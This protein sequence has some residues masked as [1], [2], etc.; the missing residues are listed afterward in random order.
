ML[1]TKSLIRKKKI[2][3]IQ[4]DKEFED[5]NIDEN[6]KII[7]NIED[8]NNIAPEVI[9]PSIFVLP[10]KQ[11]SEKYVENDEIFRNDNIFK[12]DNIIR[13]GRIG[14]IFDAELKKEDAKQDVIYDEI[15]NIYII[16]DY[17]NQKK[18]LK[19]EDILNYIFNHKDNELIK[20]YI[21]TINYNM[22]NK[23]F[24]FNLIVS[25]FTE[26]IEI[27]IKL[28]NFINDYINNNDINENIDK[29]IIF[30][31]QVIIFLFK[32]ILQV[33]KYDKLKLAKYSSY[34]S[35]KYSTMVLKKISNIEY[36]NLIIKNNLQS[37]FEIKNNLLTKLNEISSLQN[38]N[39]ERH[40]S[41]NKNITT[42]PSLILN[43]SAKYKLSSEDLNETKQSLYSDNV[44]NITSDSNSKVNIMTMFTDSAAKSENKYN[45]NNLMNFF[46]DEGS[47]TNNN[48]NINNTNTDNLSDD[49]NYQEVD[50]TS[51][52]N[53]L[54]TEDKL[55]IE[56]IKEEL[57]KISNNSNIP[58]ELSNK[59]TVSENLY[60]NNFE[61]NKIKSS[62]IKS[63]SEYSYNTNSALLNS[64]LYEL[65][66]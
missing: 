32:N 48:T 56:E 25:K 44:D 58:L 60:A 7:K 47:N 64:K 59:D 33:S 43:R 27:M 35:Y 42:E 57:S 49:N 8:E 9:K 11:D 3:S 17:D 24:E 4:S 21:F 41:L 23:Q 14:N 52:Q 19:N 45:I 51:E 63:K 34:L 61:S 2:T 16:M 6:E 12:Q 36:N 31:F 28:L 22:V 20:K 15:S 38:S 18:I 1:N 62:N 10:K 46:S 29:L 40:M 5:R 65:N 53:I 13:E 39:F 55:D 54:I 50:M 26:N 66:L 37:V 30:Y